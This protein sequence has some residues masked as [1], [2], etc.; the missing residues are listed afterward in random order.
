MAFAPL[1]RQHV[2]PL[3]GLTTALVVLPK[4]NAYAEEPISDP[5]KDIRRKPI[6]ESP[7]EDLARKVAITTPP[8][9]SGI[10]EKPQE[11]KEARRRGPTPT[12]RLA[13]HIK[14]SRLA[15]HGYAVKAEDA[16]NQAMNRFMDAEHSFT[17]TIASLAP[18][19][20]S[21]EKLLPGGIYVL[22]AAMAGSI[23]SR[24]RNI[25]LR[26]STPLITGVVA[27]HYVIPRTTENVGNL[28]WHYEKKF[29]VV[30]DNHIRVR[31]GIKHFIETGKAHSQMGLAMAQD[32]VQEAR[33]SVQD[34]VK[35]GK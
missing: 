22:V 20:E 24:N 10:T 13:E 28:I 12:D 5:I 6:Y 31:D 19:K 15:L 17:H 32:K 35:K 23:V 29:P 7:S 34:W 21:N 9:A 16:V 33:E 8:P 30:A 18:P 25:F 26:F 14:G 3:A 11:E 27:A 4:R 1:L 2:L